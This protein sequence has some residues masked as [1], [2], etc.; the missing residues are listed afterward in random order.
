MVRFILLSLMMG[1]VA[2][3]LHSHNERRAEEKRVEKV[4]DECIDSIN[5]DPKYQSITPEKRME[6]VYGCRT[7]AKEVGK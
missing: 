6:L 2:G 7:S 5:S 3:Y 1:L 4:V